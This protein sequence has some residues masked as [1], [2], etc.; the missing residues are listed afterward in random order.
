MPWPPEPVTWHRQRCRDSL[1]I[2]PTCQVRATTPKAW[3]L[4]AV[5]GSRRDSPPPLPGLTD[6]EAKAL[7]AIA[8][9]Y[10]TFSAEALAI[11]ADLEP[12]CRATKAQVRVAPCMSMACTCVL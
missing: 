6:A 1:C 5:A 12:D 4:P 11:F 10:P 8:A 2:E 7:M 3:A 9:D